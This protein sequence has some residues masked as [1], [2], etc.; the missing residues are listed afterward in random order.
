[1]VAQP[2]DGTTCCIWVKYPRRFVRGFPTQDNRMHVRYHSKIRT[3]RCV[4]GIVIYGLFAPWRTTFDDERIPAGA[5]GLRVRTAICFSPSPAY[6]AVGW[7]LE[8][9]LGWEKGEGDFKGVDHVTPAHEGIC[10]PLIVDHFIAHLIVT[11][12][13]PCERASVKDKVVRSSSAGVV[14]ETPISNFER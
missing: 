6:S 12:R 3:A 5:D 8:C 10:R 11:S 1:M 13:Y 14:D 4:I 9:A 2:D 7:R